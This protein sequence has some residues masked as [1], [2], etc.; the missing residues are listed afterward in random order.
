MRIWLNEQQGIVVWKYWAVKEGV[1]DEMS[2]GH[3]SWNTGDVQASRDAAS[4]DHQMHVS[5]IAL[6]D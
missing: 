6:V 5:H 1:N 3:Y 4:L 2:N